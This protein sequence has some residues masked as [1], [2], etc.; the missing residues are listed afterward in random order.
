MAHICGCGFYF[1]GLKNIDKE[2]NWI[3]ING[4]LD[5][6]FQEKYINTFYF[7]IITM[8]TVGYGDITPKSSDEK[9]YVIFMTI[10][11]C[12]VFAYA[13]NTSK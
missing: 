4:L 13:V 11:S 1:L 5:V 9:I 7:S 3:K 10:L 12:G 2:V 6:S 8:V